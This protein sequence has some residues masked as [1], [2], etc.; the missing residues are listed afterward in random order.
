MSDD[1]LH[2]ELPPVAPRRWVRGVRIGTSAFFGVVA[3]LFVMLW[4]RSYLRMDA[5]CR[6]DASLFVVTSNCGSISFT[7]WS[8]NPVQPITPNRLW[9]FVARV[10]DAS[11]NGNLW[12]TSKL[13]GS[14]RVPYA[15]VCMLS[16]TV[17]FLAWFRGRFSLRTMFIA[18]TLVAV[19]LWL[20][21]W[22]FT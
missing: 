12:E 8:P 9:E 21:V 11:M 18:T 14:I 13:G 6:S 1:A 16:A 22:T 17:A 2:N 10:P 19:I 4:V 3:L 7:R 20:G 5:I 15:V